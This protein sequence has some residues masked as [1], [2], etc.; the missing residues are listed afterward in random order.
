MDLQA[1][2]DRAEIIDLIT[3]YATAVDTRD[4]DAYRSV[5]TAD[6]RIDYTSA[7]G[8]AGSVSEMC[9]WLEQVLSMFS[10]TQHLVTN[11][12]IQV[13]GDEATA[14]AIVLNPMQLEGQPV[15]TM[16]G[17]YHHRLVRTP[18]GWRSREL[19]EETSWTQGMGSPEPE[20][21]ADGPDSSSDSG[22][23][24]KAAGS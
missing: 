21:A 23:A 5:F 16:G 12:Q 17:W 1:L 22:S 2:S 3:R 15:W 10:A 18:E 20:D 8:I 4:W 19:V 6:A 13:D 24:K 14:T 7:G 11:F 9:A